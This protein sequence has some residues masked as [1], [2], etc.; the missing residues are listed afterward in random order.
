MNQDTNAPGDY[1]SITFPP[2]TFQVGHHEGRSDILSSP[3]FL[4]RNK[5][6]T[7]LDIMVILSQRDDDDSGVWTF[8]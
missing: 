4:L 1:S 8:I 5:L 3:P 2:F 7:I 6:A